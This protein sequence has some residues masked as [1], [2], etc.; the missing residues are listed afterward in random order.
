[1]P[2]IIT[3]IE[4]R[5]NGIKTVIVNM[6]EIAKALHVDPAYPTKYFG[7]ELGA[8]SKYNEKT[9]AI[10]NGQ[11]QSSDLAKMLE[12]FI[13][14]FILCPT[15]RLPEIKMEVKK[16]N[17]IIDCAACGYNG[18]VPDNHKLV[19]YIVKDKDTKTEKKKGDKKGKGDKGEKGKKK[20]TPIRTKPKKKQRK[21]VKRRKKLSGS[22]TPAKKHKR[23]GKTLN[24]G[25]SRR[26]RTSR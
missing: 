13:E 21:M 6:T 14:K 19:S 8:Q 7:I 25:S 9:S 1:M 26:A 24:L 10:V 15:C 11:H 5:G 23:N 18:I 4:G 20:M 16:H 12:K 2:R 17:V 22:R 3:K